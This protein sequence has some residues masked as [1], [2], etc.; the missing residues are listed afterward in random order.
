[1]RCGFKG[2]RVQLWYMRRS[3]L[4]CFH[5]WCLLW[6][7][8][9]MSIDAACV[10]AARAHS[11]SCCPLSN[12]LHAKARERGGASLQHLY[13]VVVAVAHDNAPFAVNRN[14]IRPVELPIVTTITAT[15]GSNVAAVDISQ[16]TR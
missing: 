6:F 13:A 2:D 16:N 1:M 10:T 12:L 15:K 3:W 9:D 11:R 5:S 8:T 4:P 14:A 7:E